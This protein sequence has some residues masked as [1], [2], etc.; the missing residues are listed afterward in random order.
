MGEKNGTK[1][2]TKNIS[3]INHG[4]L[5]SMKILIVSFSGVGLNRGTQTLIEYIFYISLSET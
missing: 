5:K 4:I 3:L 1:N 2:K